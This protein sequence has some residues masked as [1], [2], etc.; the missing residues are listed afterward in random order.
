MARRLFG[1][2]K[3]HP[4]LLETTEWPQL[5]GA[6]RPEEQNGVIPMLASALSADALSAAE[7]AAAEE[8]LLE[9][10]AAFR[11]AVADSLYETSKDYQIL[12]NL[13]QADLTA[14]DEIITEMR[15][16]LE[17][18]IHYSVLTKLDDMHTLVATHIT[19]K[20]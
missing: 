2:R 3:G 10:I 1:A 13:T 6:P 16:R 8:E 4:L 9:R 12:R 15:R 19:D 7:A 5:P 18:N 14:C 20:V 17:G 11:A